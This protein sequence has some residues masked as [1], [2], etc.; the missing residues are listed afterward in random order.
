MVEL[1]RDVGFLIGSLSCFSDVRVLLEESVVL[2]SISLHQLYSKI[3]E[4][5]TP[6]NVTEACL[7]IMYAV[8]PAIRV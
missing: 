5:G 4:P 2:S 8:A 7:F 6:W 1:V 3:C